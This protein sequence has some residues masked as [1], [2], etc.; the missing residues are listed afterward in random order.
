MRKPLNI[1]GPWSDNPSKPENFYGEIDEATKLEPNLGG[2]IDMDTHKLL[3]KDEDKDE[4]ELKDFE[5]EIT[6]SIDIDK[7]IE[8][9]EKSDDPYADILKDLK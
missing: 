8:K 1:W 3:K 5:K 6:E 7:I 9:T 4:N 2:E